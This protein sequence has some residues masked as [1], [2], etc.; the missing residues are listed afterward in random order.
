MISNLKSD[1]GKNKNVEVK[2]TRADLSK[3]LCKGKWTMFK[4]IWITD[5]SGIQ[6]KDMPD[7]Q[8]VSS[9]QIPKGLRTKEFNSRQEQVHAL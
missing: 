9:I 5:M 4:S 8:A 7:I 3:K 2:N 6:I 1:L